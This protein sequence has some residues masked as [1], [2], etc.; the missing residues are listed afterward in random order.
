MTKKNS[1]QI[2]LDSL[3][4]DHL[5]GFLCI[6]IFFV[7]KIWLTKISLCEY[8]ALMQQHKWLYISLDNRTVQ[9]ILKIY[10]SLFTC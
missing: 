4:Y 6:G 1:L 9:F 3:D 10:K 7:G 8:R 2:N 5:Q